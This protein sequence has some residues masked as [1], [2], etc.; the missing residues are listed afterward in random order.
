MNFKSLVVASATLSFF[1]G[2]VAGVTRRWGTPAG[3]SCTDFTPF[4]YAGCFSDP[5]GTGGARALPFVSDLSTNNMTP[6][7]CVSFCKGNGYRYAG[8]EYYGE[9]YCGA[10]VQ[11]P[12]IDESNCDFPCSGNAS[13]ACGGN[14]I[15]SVYQDPTFPVVDNTVVSDYQFA[16]CYSEGTSG[17]SL[18]YRQNQVDSTTMTIESCLGACKLGGYPLAGVEYG[19]STTS[20][21]LP[22]AITD[23]TRESAIVV[24]S[25]EMVLR[26]RHSLTAT[27]LATATP[28]KHAAALHAWTFTLP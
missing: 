24:W 7:T 27:W 21:E 2:A 23:R 15:L 1:Q 28:R 8:I 22:M 10:S 9:C 20:L 19:V 6:D 5:A 16:G 18:V 11:G 4:T 26:R 25:S 17:R 3:P 12:Q 13:D 14:Y